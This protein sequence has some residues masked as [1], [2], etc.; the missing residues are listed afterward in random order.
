[1]IRDTKQELIETKQELIG[2]IAD[3]VEFL[4]RVYH[5]EAL[6]EWQ[7]IDMTIPQIKTLALLENAGSM[8]MSGIANYLGGTMSA[9]TSIIDRLVD[10]D[11]IERDSDPNDR[12]LVMCRL[13]NAGHR[14]ITR[15][16]RAGTVRVQP[17]LDG[18]DLEELEIVL[19]GLGLIRRES[20]AFYDSFN[21][22]QV[23]GES[24]NSDTQA[25]DDPESQGGPESDA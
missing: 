20:E 24:E 21:I 8:R 3:E 13:T 1:M 6:E 9:T 5:V 12:R 23:E 7:K 10:K 4:N 22:V 25:Q 14:T 18:L 16:W 15:F 11:L 17:F 19:A 2:Q